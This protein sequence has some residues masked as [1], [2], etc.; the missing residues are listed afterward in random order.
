MLICGNK[1]VKSLS[2]GFWSFKLEG[3]KS[4][5]Y[6]MAIWVVK[7]PR[8]VSYYVEIFVAKYFLLNTVKSRVLT[9]LEAHVGFLKL[10]MKGIFGLYIL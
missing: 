1:L 6:P 3:T 4:D 7:F 9:R 2:V 5:I 10:L 8:R